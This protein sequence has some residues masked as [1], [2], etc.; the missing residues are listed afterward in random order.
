MSKFTVGRLRPHF[1][2]LCNATLTDDICKENGEKD[3][4]PIF[5]VG[6]NRSIENLCQSYIMAGHEGYEDLDVIDKV[7]QRMKCRLDIIE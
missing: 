6:E 3:G 4:Y 1:L 7:K 2:S 5:V